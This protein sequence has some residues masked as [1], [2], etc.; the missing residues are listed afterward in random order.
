MEDGSVRYGDPYVMAAV[1][2]AALV[3]VDMG[4]RFYR[5]VDMGSSDTRQEIVMT[6]LRGLCKE[7]Q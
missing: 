1:L 3:G 7:E 4:E 5:D 2:N 6:L